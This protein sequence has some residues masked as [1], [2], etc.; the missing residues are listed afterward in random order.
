MFTLEAQEGRL[1]KP[2]AFTKTYAMAASALLSITIVPVL[3]GYLIRGKILPEKKNP[4]NRIL[5]FIYRPLLELAL[6]FK[7]L[8]IGVA[9]MALIATWWPYQKLGSEF[10]PPLYEGDL[11]Y[12]PTT[13]P[14]ISITKAKQL[15]QQTDRSSGPFRKYTMCWVKSDARKQQPTRRRSR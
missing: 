4:L 3:M 2:L 1:F 11:L 10:L 15:L 8:S 7:W 12:M 14:G 13:D 9:M 6:R 5:I